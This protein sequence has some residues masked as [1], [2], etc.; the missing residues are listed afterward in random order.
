MDIGK[1]ETFRGLVQKAPSNPLARFGLANEAMKHELWEEAL[2]QIE[3]YL[4][5]Q[6]DEGNGYGRRAEICVALG[7]SDEA[8]SALKKGIENAERH[9]HPGLAEDL[10]ERLTLLEES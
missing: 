5:L 1:L 9:G 4:A 2:E 6:D 7:Q 3:A 8:A 10:R